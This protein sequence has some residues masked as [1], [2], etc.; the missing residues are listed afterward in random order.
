[1][2]NHRTRDRIVGE[3]HL[4]DAGEGGEGAGDG[5]IAEERALAEKLVERERGEGVA[6]VEV[7]HLLRREQPLRHEVLPK[8]R[9]EFVGMVEG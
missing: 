7:V 5:G 1:M 3:R 6:R 4:R 9:H 8:P 2:V